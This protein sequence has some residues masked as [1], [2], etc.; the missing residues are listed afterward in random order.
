M[1]RL[2]NNVTRTREVYPFKIPSPQI[3]FCA[4]LVS[5]NIIFVRA[6]HVV[7]QNYNY[8]IIGNICA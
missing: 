2:K 1:F 7:A 4:W 6:F 5:L 3:L 8:L